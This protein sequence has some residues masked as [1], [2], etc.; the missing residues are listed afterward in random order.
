MTL[1]TR[2]TRRLS[3]QSNDQ[4]TVETGVSAA[5]YSERRHH[6]LRVTAGCKDA[7]PSLLLLIAEDY[8]EERVARFQLCTDF[9]DLR[10]LVLERR[11]QSLDLLLLLLHD[12][13]QFLNLAILL[14]TFAM[15]FQELV[16]Q[17]RIHCF[18]AHGVG[19]PLLVM[20]H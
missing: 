5:K 10:C 17:H 19:F 4:K 9:L 1:V 12:Y 16:E 14:L 18:I 6:P 2:K 11:G 3:R 15:F 8:L 20:Y 13:L 7:T